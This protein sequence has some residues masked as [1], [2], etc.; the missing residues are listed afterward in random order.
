MSRQNRTI[1]ELQRASLAVQYE[2]ATLGGTHEMLQEL[3][4]HWKSPPRDQAISNALLH[5]FLMAARNLLTFLYS[6][7]PR[8]SDLIAEDFFDSATEW[9]QHRVVPEPEMGNGELIGLISK[10]LAHLTW[11]RAGIERPLWGAFR[12]TWNIGLAM[13][14][15]LQIVQPVKVHPYLREDLN[16]MMSRLRSVAELWGGI[17]SAMAPTQKLMTFDELEYFRRVAEPPIT[18]AGANSNVS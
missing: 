17:P 12:I 3:G 2:L 13:Q 10:R 18:D 7:N 15:F 11:D 8:S 1:E 4:V 5:T 9:T 16:I 14:S 6:H